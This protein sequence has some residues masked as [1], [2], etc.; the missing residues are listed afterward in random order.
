VAR[1]AR[2][3][4]KPAKCEKSEELAV[5]VASRAALQQRRVDKYDIRRS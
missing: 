3:R 5:E 1:A 2:T 4:A